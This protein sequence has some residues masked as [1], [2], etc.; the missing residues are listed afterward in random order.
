MSP[1]YWPGL[2][3]RDQE[4][5]L[6][7]RALDLGVIVAR[8]DRGELAVDAG[9]ILQRRRV[10]GCDAGVPTTPATRPARSGTAW[11]GGG[12]GRAPLGDGSVGPGPTDEPSAEMNAAT[13]KPR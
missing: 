6:H 11:L 8:R 7:Q 12:L 1:T 9:A 5:H 4:V 10:H 3:Q 13:R 2:V